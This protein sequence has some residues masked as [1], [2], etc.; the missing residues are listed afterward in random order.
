M[1]DT[2]RTQDNN[3]S[4]DINF[5]DI[6]PWNGGYDTGRDVRLKWSRN[7]GKIKNALISLFSD[8]DSLDENLKQF[9]RKDQED[10]TKFI[11]R[12]LSGLEVGNYSP[13][14]LGTG[15]ALHIDEDGNSHAEFDYL[16][17]RKLAIFIELIIQEAKHVGGMLI[18]SPSGMTISK[19][20]ETD[21]AYRCYFER[22]DGDRTISNQFTVGTQARRQTFNLTEQAYY[23]RLVTAVGDDYVDLSKTD[24]DT[25]STIPKA[26]DELVGLGH[27]TDK[28]RQNAIIISSYGSDSPSIVQYSGIDSY[29]LVNKEVTV[30][31]PKRNKF[32]GTFEFE[33]GEDIKQYVDDEFTSVNNSISSLK[34]SSENIA[35]EVKSTTDKVVIAQEAASNAQDTANT[36]K[37]TASSASSTASSALNAA[38]SASNTANSALNTAKTADSNASAAKSEVASLKVQ[39]DGISLTVSSTEKKA[40]SAQSVASTA[41]STA[42]SAKDA[43]STA[44]ST[45][46]S[47]L[48]TANSASSTANSA[49]DTAKTAESNASAAKSE[50]AS[51]KVTVGSISSTVAELN[52]GNTIVSLIN[53]TATTIKLSA[54]KIDING[55]VTANGTF[56]ISTEGNITCTGGTIGGF[57]I[58]NN[59]ISCDG[60]GSSLSI[61]V[62]GGRF[63]R[64]N[65]NGDSGSMCEIRADANTALYVSSYGSTSSSRGIEVICNA[66]GSGYA[67]VTHGNVLLQ[68]RNTETVQ[69]NGLSLSVRTVSSNSNL[70][71]N[72][73]IIRFANTSNITVNMPSPKP[74]K[75]LMFIYSTG[76]VT[77]VKNGTFGFKTQ[78]GQIINGNYNGMSNRRPQIFVYDGYYW[79]EFYC[80]T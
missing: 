54:Q 12:F 10:E 2:T 33:S 17:I 15:G 73:D 38:N 29:S 59:S 64:V 11:I 55:A 16:T 50:V 36:A 27:R 9:L 56:S 47:A 20:E 21:T 51:L 63:F 32:R 76:S 40:E 37:D 44:S 48:N 58:R 8:L 72:D 45:A 23:W 52:N 7:F 1:T 61:G 49:L 13:G 3:T 24:C 67:I 4:Y 65:R 39:I 66:Q 75:V 30:I 28:E 74:G 79:C 43:A 68:A 26:G 41:Q 71:T 5:E 31:S 80:G 70:Y 46:S 14:L 53:Q 18:V 60:R 77:L 78:D 6:I 34:I 25:G 35:L 42:N 69:I 62:D 19:V 22:S 57:T